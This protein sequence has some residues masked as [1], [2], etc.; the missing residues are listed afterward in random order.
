MRTAVQAKQPL[1]RNVMPAAVNAANFATTAAPKETKKRA[2]S[3]TTKA[4]A[5]TSKANAAVAVA[6]DAAGATAKRGGAK[7]KAPKKEKLKPWQ[8]RGADG[9]LLPLPSASKPT[10]RSSFLIYMSER[11]SQLK[12]DAQYQKTSPKTG[13]QV[14][15]IVKMAKAV[16]AEWAQLPPHLKARYEAQHEQ[17]KAAY[18]QALA[19]WKA[20]LSP[21][22]IKRQNAYIASQKKK[23]IKG[24]AF[25]RDPAKPKRPNSAFFEF[26]NDLRASEAVIPNITE[27]SKRGGERW[28]QMSAE[29]KAP[30]E[31]R[32]L[33]ALEQY[34]RDLEVY[35][36]TRGP[37]L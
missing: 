30:Y 28:K 29:Q 17:E 6:A 27:F 19:E 12:G 5:G 8:A 22:D 2:S 18:E 14:V 4:K 20:A 31:Q 34:K 36:S 24:T 16:G 11:V 37:E 3:T 15:D 25:L 35:N 26:L 33:Q 13:A 21:D 1:A 32:A 7:A 10:L 23:G 9:K